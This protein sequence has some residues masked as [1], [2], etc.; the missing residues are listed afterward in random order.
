MAIKN[1]IIN[2]AVD[3]VVF[4][5]E[6]DE[7]KI[8]LIKRKNGPFRGKWALPGGF[9]ENNEDIISAAKR[10]LKEETGLG[11]LYLEQLYTFG[12]PKRD[13]RGRVISISYFALLPTH[14][15]IKS[16]DDAVDA[17]LFSV[18]HLPPLAFD[19]KK[20]V[21][22]ALTRLRNKIQ[23]TNS[24]SSMLPDNFSLGEIQNVYEII[25]DKG[26]DKRNFRKKMLSLE[27]LK[28]LLLKRKGLQSRPAKL[29]RFKSKKYVELKRFF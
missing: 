23:Y 9:I 14:K 5:I 24:V 13:S 29:Y 11:G 3:V 8:L 10:E 1:V 2:N 18:S 4:A 17:A 20:I 25:W 26:V 22:Y 16:G 27:L 7:L 19:H 12:E 6:K 28:P 15:K 21:S